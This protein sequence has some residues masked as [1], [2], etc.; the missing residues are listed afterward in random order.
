MSESIN[1]E[2]VGAAEQVLQ[3]LVHER[4]ALEQGARALATYRLTALKLQ[5]VQDA[6]VSANAT[7]EESQKAVVVAQRVKI[8]E[9]GKIDNELQ[10]YKEQRSKDIQKEID[11][12]LASRTVLVVE[13]SSLNKSVDALKESFDKA[14]EEQQ[15]ELDKAA[16]AL[17]KLKSEHRDLLVSLA[18]AAAVLGT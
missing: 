14:R 12:L 15:V 3:R 18:R 17:G 9:L 5:E 7:L 4:Q 10:Q 16:E 11:D 8:E 13:L 1:L 2:D 6:L